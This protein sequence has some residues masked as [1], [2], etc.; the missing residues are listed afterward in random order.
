M[1]YRALCSPIR[2]LRSDTPIV[3]GMPRNNSARRKR[4][5]P[6][7]TGTT[8]RRPR[9]GGRQPKRRRANTNGSIEEGAVHPLWLIGCRWH[10]VTMCEKAP[11]SAVTCVYQAAK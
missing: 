4:F 9:R 3:D 8:G 10:V 5:R 1:P 11:P 2:H 6:E 7:W